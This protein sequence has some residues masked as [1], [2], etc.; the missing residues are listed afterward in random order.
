MEP[1]RVTL[2]FFGLDIRGRVTRRSIVVYT[3][4]IVAENCGRLD[5]EKAR[6]NRREPLQVTT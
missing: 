1:L 3:Q 5:G 2:Y 4:G 6:P